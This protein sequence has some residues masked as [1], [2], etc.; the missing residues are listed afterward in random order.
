M[1][2]HMP[3]MD[4]LEATRVLRSMPA[5][6]SVPII[7]M[8]AAVLQ[9][10]RQAC[11]DAGMNGFVGKPID[12]QELMTVLR[13]WIKQDALAKVG[14][15][16]HASETATVL[17]QLGQMA[18]LDL[19]GA[20][21]RMG[22]NQGLLLRLLRGFAERAPAQADQL[23]GISTE[24]LSLWLHTLKGESANL[25][26]TTIE[27]YCKTIEAA[28]SSEPHQRP[29]ELLA[30]LG[31]YL[32]AFSQEIAHSLDEHRD[33]MQNGENVSTSQN[34]PP[35][36]KAMLDELPSLLSEQRMQALRHSEKLLEMV[37][38]TRL[39]GLY[40][41]VHALVEQLQ[42]AAALEA[43]NEFTDQLNG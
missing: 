35:E 6:E 4:G 34:N 10:D 12:P 22:G 33:A 42:F 16:S 39:H 11:F 28:L 2:M 20:L 30:T 21:A 7:A 41:P 13:Q 23:N 24:Q 14:R 3:E 25:G 37:K 27:T 29:D 43:L 40:A 17:G 36:L 31:D 38:G 5:G 8:T 9:D 1:D 18:G 32:R 19:T 26:A 15:P